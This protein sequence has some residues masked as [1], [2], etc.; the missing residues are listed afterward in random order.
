MHRS[1]DL[2]GRKSIFDNA[3]HRWLEISNVK[4]QK[5]TANGDIRQRL[6]QAATWL[7]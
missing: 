3:G 5:A 7:G 6:L 1:D 4:G 2:A